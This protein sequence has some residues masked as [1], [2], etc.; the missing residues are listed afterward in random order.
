MVYL[1]KLRGSFFSVQISHT[2]QNYPKGV[3]HIYFEHGGKDTQ[4]WAGWY[5]I[6]VTNSSITIG[7]QT[8]S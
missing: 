1:G 5:G 3:R 6:R 7:P 4:F 2:F 8:S